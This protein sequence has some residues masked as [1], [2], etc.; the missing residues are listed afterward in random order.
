MSFCRSSRCRPICS[1]IVR[2]VEP[3]MVCVPSTGVSVAQ[4][5]QVC[6]GGRVAFRD[7]QRAGAVRRCR[8]R[9]MPSPVELMAAW[10]PE[11]LRLMALITS[12]IVCMLL[13]TWIVGRVAAGV[14]DLEAARRD[15]GAAVV[16]TEERVLR[17]GRRCRSPLLRTPV[18]LEPG[19]EARGEAEFHGRV[20]GRRCRR[21][22]RVAI[23]GRQRLGTPDVSTSWIPLPAELT[24]AV[25]STFPRRCWSG[26]AV[27]VVDHVL[28]R[29]G[30]G[31]VDI[32]GIPVAVAELHVSQ[33]PQPL[34][35]VEI[36]K[37]H[38]FQPA[39]DLAA[40]DGA[41]GAWN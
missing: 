14:G 21:H 28:Q 24:S 15:A 30:A 19:A 4:Q 41:G 29:H 32:D 40:G 5:V 20:R 12:P 17:D 37:Q 1:V 2:V 13:V 22:W 27:D 39:E 8:C 23:G 38:G 6:G 36:G 16:G 3:L 34:A 26:L 35:A 31:Q 25:M 9:T 11:V 33:G 7:A 18:L 10:T